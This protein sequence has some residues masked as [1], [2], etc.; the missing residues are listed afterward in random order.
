MLKDDLLN[1]LHQKGIYIDPKKTLEEISII[2]CGERK[3]TRKNLKKITGK[4][5]SIE[6]NIKYMIEND[7]LKSEPKSFKDFNVIDDNI[8]QSRKEEIKRFLIF[9]KN[10]RNKEIKKNKKI[11]S[12]LCNLKAIFD[13]I[14]YIGKGVVGSVFKCI[15]I[16][17]NIEYPV[18]IKISGYKKNLFKSNKK[19]Y[20]N[21]DIKNPTRPEN[22]Q[23]QNHKRQ[24]Q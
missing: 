2:I 12:E 7:Y 19:N 3:I 1:L 21:L 14:Y 4:D 17:D 5:L 23:W 8:T 13:K 24:Q 20:K 22:I 18:A 16:Y 10:L 11:A 6:E 15:M 9:S